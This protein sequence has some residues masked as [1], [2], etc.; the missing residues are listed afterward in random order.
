MT[1]V[2]IRYQQTTSLLLN[3]SLVPRYRIYHGKS[4]SNVMV[5][6][7]RASY[8]SNDNLHYTNV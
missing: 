3:N 1:V 5:G 7:L 8:S 2:Q 4:P 6:L